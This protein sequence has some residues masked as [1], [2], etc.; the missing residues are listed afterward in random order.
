M[1]QYLN[2]SRFGKIKVHYKQNKS[3]GRFYAIKS[4][5]LQNIPR[6]IRHTIAKEYYVDIDIK[7][8]HPE[9]LLKLCKIQTDHR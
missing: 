9:F 3:Y 4:L 5:S 8:A 1:T 6:E 2:N 7:N